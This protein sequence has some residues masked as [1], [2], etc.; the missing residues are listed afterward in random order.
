MLRRRFHAM[1]TGCELFLNARPRP[2]AFARWPRRS[3]RCAASKRIFSRFDSD[4]ELSELNRRGTMRVGPELLEVVELAL[5]ARERTGGRFDPTVHDA[6]VAAGYDRTFEEVAA[7]EAHGGGPAVAGCPLRRVGRVDRRTR[8]DRARPRGPSRPGRDRQGLRR[9][10]RRVHPRGAGPCLVDAGGDIAV[11]GRGWPIGVET[12]D[13]TL[14]LE[15]GDG[16]VATSGRDRRRWRRGG[17]EL[18][19]LI[20]PATGLPADG[21]L[22]RVTAV[23][24]TRGEAEVLAKALFLAGA[25]EA[26]RE[27]NATGDP[28]VLVTRDGRHA[29]RRR[30]RMKSDPTFWILARSSGLLAYA[31]LTASVLAGLVLKSRPFG[32]AL[33]P[34][35][36]TDLHRFLALLGLGAVLAHASALVLDSTVPIGIAGLLVPGLAPY[37]P[38]WTG[39]GVLAAELMVVVYASFSL[40][41]RIG[42]RNWRRLH[43]ATYL[44]FALATLHGL[45]AGTDSGRTWALGL[46]GGAVGARRRRHRLARRSSHPRKERARVSHRDRPVAV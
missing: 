11:R 33:K 7:A 5:A 20:D 21:D 34:A 10:S 8:S 29:L 44:V 30:A 16:A 36:V 27:A 2:E 42:A 35:T 46:Y 31:L 12:G 24:A 37:R 3:G 23:A 40:R 32:T 4:S 1:G 6:L 22:L 18:H 15:L 45:A 14:T 26:E 13:G 28:A 19:H 38:L 25:E 39:L 17:E 43:W 41:K 9:R